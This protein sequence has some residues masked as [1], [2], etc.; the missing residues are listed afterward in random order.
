MRFGR[1][2]LAPGATERSAW[3]RDLDASMNLSRVSNRLEPE[4]LVEEWD[5][6]AV[7]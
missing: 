3:V 7:E 6:F 5:A 2:E 4:V 1:V